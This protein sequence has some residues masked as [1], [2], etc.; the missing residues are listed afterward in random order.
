MQYSYNYKSIIGDIFI[1]ADEDNLISILFK[2]NN[3]KNGANKIIK[4]TIKQLD[5]YFSGKRTSFNLPIN[6]KGTEFQKKVWKELEKIPYGETCTYKDIALRIGNPNASRAV[7]NANNKNPISIIV[8]CH[9]VIGKNKKLVGYAGGLDKKE[10][11]LTL[12][13]TFKIETTN[14]I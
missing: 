11:L 3:I 8:P 1:V 4:Q 12:E 7:G 5:E 10:K 13:K 14:S 2:S 6:P 9:R